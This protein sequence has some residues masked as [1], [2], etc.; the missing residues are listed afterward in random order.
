[1]SA[2]FSQ[3]HS[4]LSNLDMCSENKFTTD[5]DLEALRAEIDRVRKERK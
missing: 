1:M 3:I 5:E 4:A 2:R